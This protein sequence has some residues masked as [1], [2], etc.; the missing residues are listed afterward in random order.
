MKIMDNY[1][2][3][4]TKLLMENI[5]CLF[6]EELEKLL[7][8]ELTELEKMDVRIELDKLYLTDEV[9]NYEN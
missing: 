6:P 8:C 2:E 7:K 3:K 4:T 5:H 9:M 1:I